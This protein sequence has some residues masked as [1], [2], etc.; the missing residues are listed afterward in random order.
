MRKIRKTF[1]Y[2]FFYVG[3]VLEDLG[4]KMTVIG[5]DKLDSL[6]RNVKHF[7]KFARKL[8]AVH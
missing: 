7:P 2:G 8:K 6:E 1:W 5:I 4:N 3:T